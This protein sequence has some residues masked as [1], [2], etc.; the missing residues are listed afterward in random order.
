MSPG[1]YVVWLMEVGTGWL[2]WRPDEVLDA[3]MTDVV[4]AYEGKV[5][6]L[7]ACF[8]GGEKKARPEVTSID[9]VEAFDRAFGG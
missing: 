1:E 5:A 9:D 8:G 7:K 2:G 6:M 4:R 3:D